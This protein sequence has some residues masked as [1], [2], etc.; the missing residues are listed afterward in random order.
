M[1]QKSLFSSI[2][3]FVFL[4][5]LITIQVYGEKQ[6]TPLPQEDQKI[7]QQTLEQSVGRIIR[8]QTGGGG[9]FQGTLL[10]IDE[11]RIELQDA[12]G[13]ILTLA[14]D[15]ITEVIIIEKGS[16]GEIYYQDAAANKLLLMPVGFGMEPGEL[17]IAD[18]EI[19]IVSMSYGFSRA[20]SIWSAVSI[21][22]LLLNG[23][24]SFSP[25]EK[26]GISLGSFAGVMFIEPIFIGLPF[27]I[28][29]F[30]SLNNN[31]TLGIGVPLIY[32]IDRGDREENIPDSRYFIPGGILALGGKIVLSQ[33][34][35]FIT[36]NWFILGRGYD[37]T[38]D[39][40]W[41]YWAGCFPTI[42]IRIGGSRFSWDIGFTMPFLITYSDEN[43]KYEFSWLFETDLP[44]PL[45]ILGFTYRIQ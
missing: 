36:E 22:G 8:I 21:P 1:K 18:Q 7:I 20:F 5:S 35:S 33:T 30:G 26:T 11:N 14:A 6:K 39:Y 13:L 32:G 44:L 15:V 23:R 41:K 29:S 28:T 27:C 16:K 45:P 12:E 19:A 43:S 4:F 31:F 9:E 24:Y 2:F 40:W 38:R 34:A 42:A 17:H 37:I 25:G 3:L 10:E